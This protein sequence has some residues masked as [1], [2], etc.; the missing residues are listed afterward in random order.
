MAMSVNYSG[1]RELKFI[2][3]LLI[4][5]IKTRYS[6]KPFT[7]NGLSFNRGSFI[8]TRGDN[9]NKEKDLDQ[10]LTGLA[11]KY[12]VRLVPV[13]SGL[14][15]KGKDFGSEYS[16]LMKKM[17]VA[18]LCGEG[19]SSGEVGELWYFFEQELGYPVSL[20]STSNSERIDLK[21][22]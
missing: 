19:T 11:D 10:L 13:T 3:A 6:L 12:Q 15:E 18:V 4:K 22:L 1:F 5:N 2:S 20:I 21:A 14:V 17:N 8:I 9:I 7:I 16:P